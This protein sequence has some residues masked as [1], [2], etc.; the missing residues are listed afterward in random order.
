MTEK[1]GQKEKVKEKRKVVK[2]SAKAKDCKKKKA[3]KEKDH[4]MEVVIH[5]V[6]HTSAEIVQREQ[7]SGER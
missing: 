7:Q 3:A 4:C 5:V 1:V 2:G 6:D